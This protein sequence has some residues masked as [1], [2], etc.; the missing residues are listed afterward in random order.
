MAIS[1]VRFKNLDKD[2]LLEIAD[3]HIKIFLPTLS[4]RLVRNL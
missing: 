4:V 3:R 1:L 2:M